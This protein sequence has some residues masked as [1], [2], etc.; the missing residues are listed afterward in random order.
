M[1]PPLAQHVRHPSSCLYEAFCL[2]QKWVHTVGAC[3]R[4]CTVWVRAHVCLS[5]DVS[6]GVGRETAGS[7]PEEGERVSVTAAP[8]LSVT[9]SEAGRAAHLRNRIW[10]CVFATSPS[11]ELSTV[12]SKCA[13]SSTSLR[14]DDTCADTGRGPPLGRSGW[15]GGRR[16][17]SSQHAQPHS[18]VGSGAS[19]AA[20]AHPCVQLLW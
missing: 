5:V 3:T 19:R 14:G 9:S 4:V 11:H 1:L 13:V 2:L 7:H 8:A 20:S 18:E 16:G 6:G 17:I 12:P 15:H 10:D